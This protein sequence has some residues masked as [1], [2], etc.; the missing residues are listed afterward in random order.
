MAMRESLRDIGLQG[1]SSPPPFNRESGSSPPINRASGSG[2][3]S[4]NQTKMDRLHA[5]MREKIGGEL[6]RWNATRFGTVFMF[7]QSFWDKQDKF[8]AWMISSEWKNSDW[9]N[10]D[11]HLFA[12]DCLMNRIW[13]DKMELLLKSVTPIYSVLRFADQQKNGTISGFLPRMIHAKEETYGK[14]KHDDRAT[15]SLLGRFME[16]ISRRTKY[17]LNDTLMLAACKLTFGGISC[18]RPICSLLE[19]KKEAYLEHERTRCS[20]LRGN[21]SLIGGV[22]MEDSVKNYKK[23]QKCLVSQCL[24]SSGCERNWSTFAL[25]HTKLRNRIGY[26]KL[27]K[28]VYVHYNL[29]LCI[30]QFEADFHSRQEKD[31]DPCSMMMDV[32]LYDE[33]N[34]IME[35]LS[36][37]MS[38]STPTLDEYDYDEEDWTAPGSFR[39]EELEMEVEEVAAFKRKLNF[40]KKGSKKRKMRQLDDDEEEGFLDDFESVSSLHDNPVYV[41][42]GDSSSNTEGD[43]T[44]MLSVVMDL[45]LLQPMVVMKLMALDPMV[46]LL[47]NKHHFVQDQLE[48]GGRQ[49]PSKVSMNYK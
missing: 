18:N 6:I 43:V 25:V 4:G 2:S 41:E 37:S 19:Q 30:Q 10:D 39:I 34:P 23:L 49:L 9:E 31:T 42:S 33:G 29:K 7:L 26:E 11:E 5:M 21:M 15:L 12:T 14:L 8:Q 46:V 32:A 40:G 17:L 13:W 27:H 24:S 22:R 3:C 1:C 45:V 20:A 38:G 48:R 28:L 35:W 44:M 47:G 16:V 36:N